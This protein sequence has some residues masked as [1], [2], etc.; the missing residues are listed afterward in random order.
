MTCR[1]CSI[2][3]MYE[4]EK[5]LAKHCTI[6]SEERGDQILNMENIFG[7]TNKQLEFINIF[8]IISRKW[9]LLLEIQDN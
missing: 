5:H 6:F 2:P 9:N 8:N 1:G 4:D 7:S 3:G